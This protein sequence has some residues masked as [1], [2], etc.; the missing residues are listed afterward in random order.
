[1]KKNGKTC[2][3]WILAMTFVFAAC[4]THIP[5]SA[6]TVSAASQ[7]Y[8]VNVA[9]GYLALRTEMAYDDRN[10]IAELYNGDIVEFVQ[11]G[12][13]TYWYVYSPKHNKYGYVNSN[14]LVATQRVIATPTPAP[15]R[16]TAVQNGN[17]GVRVASGYL[18][19]RSAMAYDVRNEIGEL[20]NGDTVQYAGPGN[21]EYWYV[22]SPKYN[23]YGYVNNAYLYYLNTVSTP[24]V[25][26]VVC[27]TY[28]VG[29]SSGY[30]ALRSAMAFDSRNEIGALYTGDVVLFIK[31]GDSTYWY[32]YSPKYDKYG[33][34]NKSYLTYLYN[35][36]VNVASGTNFR[37]SVPNGY[38]ALRTA[39]AYDSN[40]E[41]GRLYTGDTVQYIQDGNGTYWYVYSPKLGRYGY[42]NRVYVH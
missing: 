38:L 13:G 33:Y 22:Y 15:V 8:A 31:E 19:L 28:Q 20:Y 26:G 21:T 10:I 7:N 2:L 4:L 27:G 35:N 12:N 39:M 18:A 32:V 9:S 6:K 40:N 24:T 17:Y 1:M 5:G 23:K 30:L 29:V 3:L 14:Y 11:N 16:P 36:Y 37:V 25:T 41:I 34:V 42:V